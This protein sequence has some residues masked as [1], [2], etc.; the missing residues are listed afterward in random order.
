MDTVALVESQIDN[1][2]RLLDRLREEG[3]AVRA[4][5]WVKPFDE[6]R[7]TLYIATPSVDEKGK[8]EAYRQLTPALRSLGDAW[9]TSSDVTLVGGEHPIA[10]DALEVLRRFPHKAPIRSPR[11]LLGGVPVEAVYVY[12]PGEVEVIVYHLIFPG[13]PPAECG[14]L[15]LDPRLLDG[16]Y[17][18]EVESP[19]E[20]KEYQGK[21]G[22]SCVVAAPEGAKLE[23]DE[24]GQMVLAWDRH[25][26]RRYSS[27]NEVWSL[28]DLREHGFRILRESALTEKD[29]KT[30][31]L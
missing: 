24:T 12:P 29:Q 30:G 26:K 2:R 10:R 8:L 13:A 11:S 31:D 14:I 28:A 18:V 21:T 15:S 27:A 9:V 1:G 22:I 16:R 17:S 3:V 6:D 23:R 5:C 25:G 20:R 19:G 7:W 4:A